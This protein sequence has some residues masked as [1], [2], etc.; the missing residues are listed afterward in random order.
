VLRGK[1]LLE[2]ILGTPPPPPPP[3]VP[4]LPDAV[5]HGTP[6]SIRERMELHRKNPAC[7]GCHARMDPL[8]FA[9][10]NF[11]AV[12]AWRTK[13][14][15]QPID[16]SGQL[17][18]G[19]QVNGA[20][21]LRQALLS[22]PDVLVTTLT[23]KLMTYG[24]GRGVGYADMPTVRTIVRDAAANNYRFSSLVLGIVSSKPFQMRMKAQ[25][26]NQGAPGD[27]GKR[28]SR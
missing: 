16:V 11:D 15:G 17:A 6:R 19:T 4:D 12:G 14:G 26:S 21:M 13:D 10:E 23:E 3:D 18:D 9:L 5:D 25:D 2:N 24:V 28:A 22:K 7:A 8:G 1:W 27:Q 20:V